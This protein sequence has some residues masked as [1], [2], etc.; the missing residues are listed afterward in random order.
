[1]SRA[2]LLKALGNQPMLSDGGMGTQ[3]IE[4]GLTTADCG[5]VWNVDRP[6]VIESVHRRYVEAGCELV[7]TNTFQASAT[8]LAMHGLADRAAE[9]SRAGA[10]V[11]R[12]AAGDRALVMADIGPFGGFL[13][14]LGE[15]TEAELTAIFTEQLSAMQEGGADLVVVETMSD[16]NEVAVAVRAAK[17]LSDWPVIATYA[18]QRSG[19]QFTTMMGTSVEDA[20]AAAADAGADVIGAN[21]GT[22]LDLDAYR[23]LG[24]ALLTAAGDKPVILQPNAGSPVQQDGQTVY[25]ATPDDMAQLAGDLVGRGIKVVG[26]CCGTTPEHLAAM[27]GKVNT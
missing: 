26:G 3:L 22:A 25:L 13:E 27:A 21:C 2:D 12:R 4:A 23:Q 14:P 15:T 1:M 9:L 8:A 24:D 17:A 10:Q 16:P 5:V 19:D 7:T 11:A 6:D 20:L 18:F